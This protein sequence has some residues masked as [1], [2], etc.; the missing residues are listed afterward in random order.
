MGAEAGSRLMGGSLV[1]AGEECT[2]LE[3]IVYRVDI[4]LKRVS[5]NRG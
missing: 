2:W 1:A 5:R 3:D 4:D